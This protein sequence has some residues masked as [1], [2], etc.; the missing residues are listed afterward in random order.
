MSYT[1]CCV[2]FFINNFSD[3]IG[4]TIHNLYAYKMAY[5]RS[6]WFY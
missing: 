6:V 5:N 4:D 1:K 2:A 3:F